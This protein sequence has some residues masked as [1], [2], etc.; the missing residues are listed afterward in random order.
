MKLALMLAA[1]A[2]PLVAFTTT[3]KIVSRT[4]DTITCEVSISSPISVYVPWPAFVGTDSDAVIDIKHRQSLSSELG[5]NKER[6]IFTIERAYAESDLD[7]YGSPCPIRF[8]F[9]DDVNEG[10]EVV[11][12]LSF[13]L[14]DS[15]DFKCIEPV[16]ID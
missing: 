16:Y 14:Y 11:Y 15:L 1:V 5:I 2:A 9:E 3:G 7:E 6:Y 4:P 12:E 13:G 10:A 8:Y